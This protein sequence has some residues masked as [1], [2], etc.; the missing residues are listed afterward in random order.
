MHDQPKYE[1]LER[2][3]FFGDERSARPI[4]EGTV[5]RGHLRDILSISTGNLVKHSLRLFLWKLPQNSYN[6]AS[7]DTT[8]F[9]HH[10]MVLL[11]MEPGWLYDVDSR[12]RL[13]SI[14]I[15]YDNH[16][17]VIFTM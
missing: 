4:V 8:F 7:S 6:A 12:S 11:E 5:A 14:L 10:V 1:P 9:A 13:H 15:V 2:S 3:T 17:L 16:L